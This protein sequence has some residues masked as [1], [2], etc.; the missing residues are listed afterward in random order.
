MAIG[1]RD[2]DNKSNIDKVYDDC[3]NRRANRFFQYLNKNKFSDI[4]TNEE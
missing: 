4:R 1:N 2:S 3:G